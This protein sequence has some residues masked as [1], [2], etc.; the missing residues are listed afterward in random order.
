MAAVA[1]YFV[2]GSRLDRRYDIQIGSIAVPTDE[3]SIAR[4][5]HLAEA[6]TACQA[7]HGEDLAGDVL[8]EEPGIAAV[9]ASNLTSGRGGVG[10]AY[11]DADY[12]RAI[13]HGV[14]L[15][16]RGLLIMHADLF[17]NL[18]LEDLAA[19]IAYVKSV[20]PVDNEVPKTSVAPL[21]RVMLALGLFDSETA[22]LIPAEVIDHDA[23]FAEA[24]AREATAE[25]GQYL[26]SITLC[27][28]CHGAGLRGG[29]SID[30]GSPPGPDIVVY[31][32][33]GGWSEE[34]FIGAMRTGVTPY[35]K[36]LDPEFMPWDPIFMKMTDDELGAIWQYLQ[37]L[38][39]E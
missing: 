30:A 29:P 5:R 3:A 11:S 32:A 16:G 35:G 33:P 14:N 37:S 24:P 8:F 23:P 21:G 4:G 20:S 2:G 22:P 18:S 10:T 1:L 28:L 15:E 39:N 36:A 6:V 31:A 34:Q 7:C 26:T 12:V 27:S 17:H 25:Y 9:Y 19:L 13:R 38:A